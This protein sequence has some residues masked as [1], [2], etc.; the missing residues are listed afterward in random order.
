VTPNRAEMTAAVVIEAEAVRAD[1]PSVVLL[2]Q[3]SATYALFLEIIMA[4]ILKQGDPFD[5]LL[6]AAAWQNVAREIIQHNA[7]IVQA[8]TKP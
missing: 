6:R 1:H 4:D 5:A 7:E 8:V 3:K 2:A